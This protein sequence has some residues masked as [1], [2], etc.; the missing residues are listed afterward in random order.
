MAYT[1]SV[2]LVSG[3][4]QAAQDWLLTAMAKSKL[5]L[6]TIAVPDACFVPKQWK[7]RIQFL[8]QEHW[9][10]ELHFLAAVSCSLW[11]ALASFLVK[12]VFSVFIIFF[13]IYFSFASKV[14][15]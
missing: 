13:S 2:G 3:W 1:D 8:L 6:H 14:L 12:D 15:F 11:T 10:P 4:E 9:K 5:P 7:L